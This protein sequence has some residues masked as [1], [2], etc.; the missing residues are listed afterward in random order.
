[1]KKHI[2]YFFQWV[3]VEYHCWWKT[4]RFV[5]S[6]GK[7]NTDHRVC[8]WT[9]APVTGKPKKIFCTCG[10]NNDGIEFGNFFA[11]EFGM[12]LPDKNY[13]HMKRGKAK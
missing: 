6:L 8:T 4:V 9:P 5:F 3:K 7:L 2:R 10:Y 11:Q 13:A 1:M 12:V